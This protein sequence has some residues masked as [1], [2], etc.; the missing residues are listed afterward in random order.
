MRNGVD[1]KGREWEKNLNLMSP[2]KDI[3]GKRFGS[4]TVLFR[5]QNDKQ[6]N[7]Y[8]LC[9]CD[10]SN[11]FVVR[12]TSLRSG[13]TTSCGCMKKEIISEK[14]AYNFS[15]GEKVGYWTILYKANEYLGKGSYWHCRCE[16]GVEKD[17]LG[18]SLFKGTSLSC[19]CYNKKINSERQL[20]DLTGKTYGFL[21]VL[22]I[23]DKKYNGDV[24]WNVRCECGTEKSV[25]GHN[26]RRGG[27]ISCG[28]KQCS[29]GEMNVEKILNDNDIL[30]KPQYTF[31][32]L[33]SENNKLLRFDF[34]II[35]NNL[36]LIRLIEFDGTQ[37]V[38]PVERF[39]GQA[40]FEKRQKYDSIKNQ[41]ALSHNIPLVRIPYSKRNS[42]CLDDILGDKYLIKE[43]DTHG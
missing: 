34:G 2:D 11:D 21:T 39:G 17:V 40:E 30:F 6:G 1:C 3:T 20:I 42:M 41:Y 28:C 5:V 32:D 16:C 29:I 43:N 19:G 24:F 31:N 15:P 12:G 8:W 37:H 36:N 18:S 25:S 4:L 9:K 10:C 13:H 38:A 22:G 26:L 23:S 33:V 7:S 35:D 14:L 27:V